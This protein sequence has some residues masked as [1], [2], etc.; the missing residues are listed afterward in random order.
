MLTSDETYSP[1]PHR[2]SKVARATVHFALLGYTVVPGDRQGQHKVLAH[3]G[4]IVWDARAP[5]VL[6]A[7]L[8]AITFDRIYR[9]G[10]P[11]EDH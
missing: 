7:M 1:D 5:S 8:R 11:H 3:D 9:Q 6:F 4:E 10:G 2:D